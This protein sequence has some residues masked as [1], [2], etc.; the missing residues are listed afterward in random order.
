MM[1]TANLNKQQL[2][3]CCQV[4][5]E[6][7][8]LTVIAISVMLKAYTHEQRKRELVRKSP[9][10]T[11]RLRLGGGIRGGTYFFPLYFFNTPIF[12]Q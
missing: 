5:K 11:K 6:G 10:C 3:T 1:I 4:K 7:R 8:K 9:K 2:I 12:L